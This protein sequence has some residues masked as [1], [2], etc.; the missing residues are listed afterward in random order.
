MKKL[1]ISLGLLALPMVT[2]AGGFGMVTPIKLTDKPVVVKE[3]KKTTKPVV[4][5]RERKV[6]RK[7]NCNAFERKSRWYECDTKS[8]MGSLKSFMLRTRTE[9]FSDSVTPT[10]AN[11]TTRGKDLEREF[12]R[13]AAARNKLLRYRRAYGY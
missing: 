9:R 3:V 1:G 6:V 4:L 2:M 11:R 8:E 12:D 5:I 10:V 7:A 13:Q